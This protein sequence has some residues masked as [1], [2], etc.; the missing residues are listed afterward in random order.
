MTPVAG[1]GAAC[2]ANGFAINTTTPSQTPTIETTVGKHQEHQVQQQVI[3]QVPIPTGYIYQ[4]VVN[5]NI[6]SNGFQSYNQQQVFYPVTSSHFNDHYTTTP[7]TIP[8]S[9][10][11]VSSQSINV[12]P[13]H[14][15]SYG[16]YETT[17]IPTT[18]VNTST[19]LMRNS[20][21]STTVSTPQQENSPPQQITPTES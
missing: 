5:N 18:A 15:A 17:I 3:N 14:Y 9:S 11:S 7:T 20:N 19:G 10:S 21:S 2:D 16:N 6:S 1:Q 4:N 13:A 12:T 8:V